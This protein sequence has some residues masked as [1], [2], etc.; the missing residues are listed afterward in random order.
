VRFSRKTGSMG[1]GGRARGRVATVRAGRSRG[2]GAGRRTPG[3]GPG[4]APP[5]WRSAPTGRRRERAPRRGRGRGRPRRRA[6]KKADRIAPGG[7]ES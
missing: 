2:S 4:A 7:F 6:R 5:D 3:A 1:A